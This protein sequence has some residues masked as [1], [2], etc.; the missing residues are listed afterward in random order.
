MASQSP[1]WDSARK[2]ASAG[3]AEAVGIRGQG[4]RRRGLKPGP[5]AKKRRYKLGSQCQRAWVQIL[6]LPLP[7]VSDVMLCLRFL[8]WKMEMVIM[9]IGISTSAW[10]VWLRG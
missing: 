1:G 2:M 7:G 8:I 6:P 10:P 4:A 3:E 9:T 5:D